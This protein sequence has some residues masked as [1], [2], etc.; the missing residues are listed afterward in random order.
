MYKKSTLT[1]K[2]T[3]K[4][5]IGRKG[6]G[7]KGG[8]S[9]TP[10]E[11]RFPASRLQTVFWEGRV[12][13]KWRSGCASLNYC[14]IFSC[15]I[16]PAGQPKCT[17][18]PELGAWEFGASADMRRWQMQT[19]QMKWRIQMAQMKKIKVGFSEEDT[20]SEEAAVDGLVT[21]ESDTHTGSLNEEMWETDILG[22]GGT[23]TYMSA[24]RH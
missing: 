14:M 19:V 10:S 8:S 21:E 17:S 1:I 11:A 13:T 24:Y 9:I 22:N 7:R 16:R 5:G 18:H 4:K 20:F 23:Q 15:E 3:R 12:N 6:K 2:L